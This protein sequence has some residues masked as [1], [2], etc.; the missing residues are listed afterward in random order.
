MHQNMN[1]VIDGIGRFAVNAVEKSNISL[2]QNKNTCGA[3]GRPCFIPTD[4]VIIVNLPTHRFS[5][6]KSHSM[7]M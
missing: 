7:E 4:R 6:Y 3:N 1:F 5:K 2:T